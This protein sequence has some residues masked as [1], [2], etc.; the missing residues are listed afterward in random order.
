MIKE[1]VLSCLIVLSIIQFGFIK[2]TPLDDYVFAPDPN[3]GYTLL[4][5]YTMTGYTLL[6]YNFTSQKWYDGEYK[7]NLSFR[8]NIF[9]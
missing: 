7:F 6:I 2:T 9:L 5:T 8:K 3:Y 1:S 4:E